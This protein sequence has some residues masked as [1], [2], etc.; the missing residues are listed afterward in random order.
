MKT[1]IL[2]LLALAVLHGQTSPNSSRKT[3]PWRMS[4]IKVAKQYGCWL[5]PESQMGPPWRF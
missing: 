4:C 1:G 3:Q 5:R 2:V